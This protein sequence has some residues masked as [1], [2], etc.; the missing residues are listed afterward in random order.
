MKDGLKMNSSNVALSTGCCAASNEGGVVGS[1]A[2]LRSYEDLAIL[3]QETLGKLFPPDGPFLSLADCRAVLKAVNNGL[4]ALGHSARSEARSALRAL[5]DELRL[6]DPDG[7]R[8]KEIHAD[9]K[10]TISLRAPPL[11]TLPL[12]L[13][14]HITGYLAEADVRAAGAVNQK[15]RKAT[16]GRLLAQQIQTHFSVVL[17]QGDVIAAF[18]VFLARIRNLDGY[19]QGYPLMALSERLIRLHDLTTERGCLTRS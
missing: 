13:V 1:Q 8:F 3:L 14:H 4:R 11:N 7:K 5:R 12:G 15:I 16:E 18:Q 19:M 9:L 6:S 2:R 10:D 17:P